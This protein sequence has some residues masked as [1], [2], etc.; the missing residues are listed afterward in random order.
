M[1]KQIF[2]ILLSVLTLN[3]L[4][5]AS[6]VRHMSFL[7]EPFVAGCLVTSL[8]GLKYHN[9]V[10]KE[11]LVDKY[12]L[13][14][15]MILDKTS[16]FDELHALRT[17]KMI[18][19]AILLGGACAAAGYAIGKL[20]RRSSST[21]D[22]SIST[23][24]VTNQP[25]DYTQMQIVPYVQQITHYVPDVPERTGRGLLAINDTIEEVD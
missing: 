3:P 23:Q 19:Q 22:Q 11:M 13:V 9:S 16:T 2:I 12:N 21:E 7:I 1:K 17:Q 4:Q 5:A 24:Q 15:N 14:E 20:A 25:P 10:V 8:L 6:S 18:L